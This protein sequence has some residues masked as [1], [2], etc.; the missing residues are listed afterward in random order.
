MGTARAGWAALEWT[1]S[2]LE[3]IAKQWFNPSMGEGLE[4]CQDRTHTNFGLM[5]MTP[6][7][8]SF[9]SSSI[10]GPATGATDWHDP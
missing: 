1:K 10:S 6:S 7:A 8:R 5:T 2:A 3:M 9:G 4:K